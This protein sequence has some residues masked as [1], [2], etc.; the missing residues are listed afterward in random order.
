MERFKDEYLNSK[1][2]HKRG[3]SIGELRIIATIMESNIIIGYAIMVEHTNRVK[4]YTVS[5]TIALLN[6]YKFINAEL[7]GNNVHITDSSVNRLPKL[8]VGLQLID[9]TKNYVIIKSKLYNLNSTGNK[10]YL[11]TYKAV[12]LN[13]T[14]INII[15][16]TD[17]QLIKLVD[18]MNYTLVN[19]KLVARGDKRLISAL[20]GEFIQELQVSKNKI[21]NYENSSIKTN[22]ILYRHRLHLKKLKSKAPKLFK[23]IIDKSYNGDERIIMKYLVAKL[24][25]VVEKEQE[26]NIL[27]KEDLVNREDFNKNIIKIQDNDKVPFVIKA[28]AVLQ[29]YYKVGDINFNAV[30]TD[31]IKCLRVLQELNIAR[32]EILKFI[33]DTD[34]Y[35]QNKNNADNI[36]SRKEFRVKRFNRAKDIAELGFA[37]SEA[38]DGLS[39]KTIC[40]STYKLKF[41]GKYITNFEKYKEECNCF[42]DLMSLVVIEKSLEFIDKIINRNWYIEKDLNDE[43]S[44]QIARIEIALCMLAFYNFNLAKL[45]YY[46]ELTD[47]LKKYKCT[48]GIGV[49]FDKFVD[50]GVNTKE[51]M[52]IYYESG[53]CVVRNK[54][55]YNRYRS[56]IKEGWSN[57]YLNNAELINARQSLKI[58]EPILFD[59]N[60]QNLVCAVIATNALKS[61]A[62][63]VEMMLGLMRVV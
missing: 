52:T 41:V 2:G 58:N 50:L 44:K 61:N 34:K 33:E 26:L 48:L 30:N 19:A 63:Y 14:G 55:R 53:Y 59:E 1:I 57:R 39:Y 40:G 32:P 8:S 9:N 6:S 24:D 56:N 62:N 10:Q 38:N 21:N 7:L 49:D 29:Y 36:K 4:P 46:E 28:V 17:S 60:L 18:N 23:I 22:K 42:G 31:S 37:I 45:Y 20:K 43:I 15:N 13:A 11:G 5:Q 3:S 25:T 47:K 54:G 27:I 16:M 35:I 51:D 12:V